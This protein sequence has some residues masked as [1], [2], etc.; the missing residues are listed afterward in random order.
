MALTEIPIELSSTP[1]IVDGGNATAITIDSS[2]NIALA[3]NITMSNATSPTILMTDTTNTVSLKMFSGNTTGNIG[4]TTNH[5]L[6]LFTNDTERMNISAAGQVTMPSQPAFNVHPASGQDNIA[7]NTAVTVVFGTERF[8][9]GANFA[10]NTFTAPVTGKYQLNVHLQLGPVDS[11]AGFY[12]LQLITS[13]RSYDLTVDPNFSADLT[14]YGITNSVLADMDA[15]DTA[16]IKIYQNS[17]TA[18]TDISA[19]T[20]FSGYLVA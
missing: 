17:G 13:N 7:I 11:A 3:G 18:Q 1:S 16:I 20:S 9:I 4:I 15:S 10:S 14:Y 12:Q 2:E 5:P 6:T 19:S 8:D